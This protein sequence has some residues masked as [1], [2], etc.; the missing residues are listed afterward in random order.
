[1]STVAEPGQQSAEPRIRLTGVDWDTFW[2]L[3]SNS[4]GARFAFDRGVLEIMSPGPFHESRKG[5]TADFVRIASLGLRIPRLPM[6][7]TTWG[8]EEAARGIEADECFY[9]APEKITAAN[10]AI[11]RMS[12]DQSDYPPP[13]MAVEVDLRHPLID[14]PSIFATIGVTELWRFAGK[15]LLIEQL[16]D[17]GT[18]AE[19]AA[20]RFLPISAK[21]AQRWLIDED[22]SDRSAWEERVAEWARGLARGGQSG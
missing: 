11:A 6:G 8:N 16:Q 10:E 22:S 3:A 7:S 9:F 19:S 4:R 18:Y 2:A 5:L 13:D 1:M 15:T 21:E 17:D 14:R 20:S 12:N